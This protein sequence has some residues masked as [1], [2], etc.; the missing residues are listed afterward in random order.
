MLSATG[1]GAIPMLSVVDF[2]HRLAQKAKTPYPVSTKRGSS[3]KPVKW[4][5]LAYRMPEY[6]RQPEQRFA[7]YCPLGYQ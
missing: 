6:F 3:Q 7:L 1:S 5:L 2:E 4:P